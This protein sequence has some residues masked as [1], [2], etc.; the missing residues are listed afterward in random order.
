MKSIIKIGA[1]ALLLFSMACVSTKSRA[2]P[3]EIA[4]FDKMIDHKH[5]EIKALLA[6]PLAT[7][8]LNSI[9][10]AGLLPPGSTASL[11]DISGTGGYFRMVGDSVM[12]DLPFYGERRM[13]G[14][15]NQNKTGIQ[16]EGIPVELSFSPTKNGAGQTMRFTIDHESEGFQV[17][18]QLYP[19]GKARLTV[20]STHRTNMW[21]QGNLSEYKK[22]E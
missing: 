19:N 14:Y 7:Q 6:Q 10:N 22:E 17:I 2:T 15:Y 16:F 21:Y 4:A 1:Y 5:F 8:S 9:A 3:E 11:I 20:S 12:A 13:G 18:A